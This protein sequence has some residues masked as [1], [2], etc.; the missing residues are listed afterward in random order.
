MIGLT[1]NALDTD[2]ER[3]LAAGMD[4]H[5]AKPVR[6]RTLTEALARA[7]SATTVSL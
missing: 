4:E 1:A 5:V 2:R 6:K 7:T 3:C